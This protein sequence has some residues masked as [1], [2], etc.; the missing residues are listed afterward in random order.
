MSRISFVFFVGLSG[1]MVSGC[2]SLVPT[3]TATRE[4][5]GT[6]NVS[7]L[8]ARA[9]E[10][11]RAAD[12]RE[13]I[14]TLIETYESV[15]KVDPQHFQA[16][17]N[18]AQ[19][20]ILLGTGYSDKVAQKKQHFR[21]AITYSER[22]MY[23]NGDFVARVNAGQMPWEASEAL[24]KN[25][26]DGMG[27]WTTAVFYYF[28]ECIPNAFK[29]FNSRWIKRNKTFMD[30]IEAV[31]PNWKGGAN[32]FNLGIYYL[33]LPK[34]F[35]GDLKK[36]A[37]YLQKAE[38]AGPDRLLIPWGRAK[39]YYY[40]EKNRQGFKK[41]LEWVLAQDPH[42]PTGDTYPWNVYFQAQARSLLASIDEL[43]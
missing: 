6:D 16:L 30:R 37:E 38:A 36:S 33:A 32:Y 11:T 1:L 15:L 7:A 10:Q 2:L 13:K 40:H 5:S 3:S 25:E 43:F 31:D 42:R 34:S 9:E 23:L 12:T 29:M 24:T 19:Y 14:S 21:T 8:L 17:S 39:Y 20:H 18:L 35:G 26:A 4:P 22:I 28:K 41:D 27:W